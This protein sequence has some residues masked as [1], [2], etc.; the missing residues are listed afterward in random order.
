MMNV[1]ESRESSSVMKE[2]VWASTAY[3]VE[4]GHVTRP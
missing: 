2:L 1:D 3:D 4:G